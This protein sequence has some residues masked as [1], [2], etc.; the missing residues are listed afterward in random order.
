M[1]VLFLTL[2]VFVSVV[3]QSR[4]INVHAPD[5]AHAEAAKRIFWIFKVLK[6][7]DHDIS[8]EEQYLTPNAKVFWRWLLAQ[9]WFEKKPIPRIT[10]YDGDS[11]NPVVNIV[12][13]YP[14]SYEQGNETM[15]VKFVCDHGVYKLDE[16]NLLEMKG[17]RFNGM[18]LSLVVTNR[19]EADRQFAIL[20]PQI[21]GGV[22]L[23]FAKQ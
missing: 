4:N 9:N 8:V 5:S 18:P 7:S 6:S 3:F 21:Q 22:L 20:N 16:V 15:G 23:Q 17:A 2:V 11:L 19:A 14:T 13:E 1:G 12:F 10:G